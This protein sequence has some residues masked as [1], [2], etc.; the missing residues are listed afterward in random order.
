MSRPCAIVGGVERQRE[1]SVSKA[2]QPDGRCAS[3]SVAAILARHGEREL[4]PVE[5]AQ[6]F[7]HLPADGER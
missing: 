3:L 5:F 1:A 2:E 7:G 6:R 4:T